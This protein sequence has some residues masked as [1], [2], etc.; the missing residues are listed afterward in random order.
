LLEERLTKSLVRR[1]WV[2]LHIAIR[3][4]AARLAVHS[5]NLRYE[6]VNRIDGLLRVE[7]LW[8]SLLLLLEIGRL[9]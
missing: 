8:K 4:I 9:L 7:G 3:I 1:S 5:R 6:R 2:V